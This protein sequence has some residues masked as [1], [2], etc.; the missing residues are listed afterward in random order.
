MPPAETRWGLAVFAVL[1]AGVAS[2]LLVFQDKRAGS[3]IETSAITRTPKGGDRNARAPEPQS[4]ALAGEGGTEGSASQPSAP[5]QQ[6][7]AALAPATDPAVNKAEIIRGVQRELNTRGYGTGQPDG[8]AGLLTRAAIMAYEHDYGLSLTADPTQEFLSR[9][10]LGTA[11]PAAHLKT[12]PQVKTP[13][14]E[15]VVKTVKQYLAALGYAP[16]KAD[17]KLTEDTIRAIRDFELD[18]KMPESGRVSGQLVSRLMRLQGQGK[19]AARG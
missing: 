18:Q 6:K 7:T 12:Q 17:G 19:T 9:I 10:V 5:G 11:G 14:A 4:A 8:V 15:A 3:G 16:G 2:N 1:A 13:E